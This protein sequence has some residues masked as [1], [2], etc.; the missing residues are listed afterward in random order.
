MTA[1]TAS[2]TFKSPGR[3]IAAIAVPVSLEMVIQLVL[4]FV[5]QVIVGSLGAVAVATGLDEW[6]DGAAHGS[7]VAEGAIAVD[8]PTV[9][10]HDGEIGDE[11]QHTHFRVLPRALTVYSPR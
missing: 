7:I 4:T 1:L 9:I 6:A 5:N 8:G 11:Y 2:E 3:E 10:A